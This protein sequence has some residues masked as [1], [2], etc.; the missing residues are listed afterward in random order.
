MTNAPNPLGI[1]DITS[2]LQQV[3]GQVAFCFPTQKSNLVPALQASFSLADICWL[4]QHQWGDIRL[5]KFDSA[6]ARFAD[7]APTADLLRQAFDQGH[8]L[9]VDNL[10]TKNGL[11]ATLCRQ[12]SR[13]FACPTRC[14]A[15]WSPSYSEGQALQYDDQD[16]FVVQVS[17]SSNW[18]VDFNSE[19]R[20]FGGEA[21][22]ST[23]VEQCKTLKQLKLAVGD[24][25]YLPRGSCYK[26]ATGSEQ[27]LHF[28]FSVC[29]L[30]LRDLLLELLAPARP[31]L[32][33]LRPALRAEDFSL[34]QGEDARA[35]LL[36]YLEALTKRLRSEPGL[37]DDALLAV[38]KKFAAQLAPLNLQL[39]RQLH[40]GDPVL[41]LD[42]RLAV[43][44][45]QYFVFDEPA[46]RV[47]FSGGDIHLP[48]AYRWVFDL[49]RYTDGFSPRDIISQYQRSDREIELDAFAQLLA[50][51][52]LWLDRQT[53]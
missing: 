21:Y 24:I 23:R 26:A 12:L 49:L 1:P 10:Q 42:T 11:F 52:L 4:N 50:K 39:D 8:T 19:F 38:H 27:S 7:Q 31:D 45:E 13:Q 41:T 2:F 9:L 36:G 35:G 6:D 22:Q 16:A 47:Y 25:L 48:D 3:F 32:D 20:P 46:Q 34:A 5:A 30:R 15:H 43:N 29:S 51:D 44:P 40:R 14:L 28:T 53:P 17:G 18:Q 37:A 33:L